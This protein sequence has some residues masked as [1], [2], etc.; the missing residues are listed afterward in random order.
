MGIFLDGDKLPGYDH[1][2]T[3][4]C[5]IDSAD[6]SG[7]TSST[8]TAHRGYKAWV[9]QV[10]TSINFENADQLLALRVM[11]EATAES[12]IS[13]QTVD[14]FGTPVT[15]VST[16]ADPLTPRLYEIEDDTAAALGIFKVRFADLF[17][18]EPLENQKR[19]EVTFHMLEVRSIPEKIAERAP[20]AAEESTTQSAAASGPAVPD[21]RFTEILATFDK[22]AAGILQKIIPSGK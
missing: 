3:A 5:Q 16:V 11:F 9:L 18:V 2:V 19:W 1:R 4:Q 20:A 7:D 15:N 14:A 13:E 6:L 17:K 22:A 10:R 8:A 12:E 21:T